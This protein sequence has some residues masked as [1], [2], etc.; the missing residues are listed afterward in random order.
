ME[1]INIGKFGINIPSIKIDVP[2]GELIEKG[3]ITIKKEKK[4]KEKKKET[5]M[6]IPEILKNSMKY[7]E[8]ED[9][10]KINETY[11]IG[12]NL[13]INI[14]YNDELNTLTYNVIEP[15]ISEQLS[16]IY[17]KIKKHLINYLNINKFALR[18]EKEL[19]DYIENKITLAI[20]Q[21]AKNITLPQMEELKYY[22]KRDLV[23]LGRL[24]PLLMD[25]NVEQIDCLGG[26]APIYVLHKKYINLPTNIVFTEEEAN[27]FIYFLLQ[28]SGTFFKDDKPIVF[29][30]L[31]DGSLLE[32]ISPKITENGG[33]FIIKK[34]IKEPNSILELI[35][36]NFL[37]IPMAA[38]IWQM[39][40][41]NKTLVFAGK[42]KSGKH[43]LLNAFSN[44]IKP[45]QKTLV[46][47][48]SNIYLK[49]VQKIHLKKTKY[50]NT[51]DLVEQ[52]LKQ[53]PDYFIL[54]R[55]SGFEARDFFEYSVSGFGAL[56]TFFSYDIEL[57]IKKLKA[58]G[59]KDY[60]LDDSVFIF[61]DFT[62]K[63]NFEYRIVKEIYEISYEGELRKNLVGE[64]VDE[65]FLFYPR[66][67]KFL[68][69]HNYKEM[70]KKMKLLEWLHANKINS[71]S[72]VY[73][74]LQ[75]EEM[76]K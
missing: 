7:P 17:E 64:F 11:Q 55:V 3:K 20:K 35:D 62:R 37:S 65:N 23:G 19:N 75:R 66:R 61:M 33:N 18:N 5:T 74:I 45:N 26:G 63:G 44:L 28:L 71:F 51:M 6:E 70:D 49:N 41:E 1:I 47:D 58:L 22:L 53:L 67:S 21:F 12:D 9:Y 40:Q 34:N 15:P 27:N 25:K 14:R 16:G 56:T 13:F 73:P 39:L 10:K 59:V 72:E 32:A 52:G 30:N 50:I 57:T 54:D 46:I 68:T 24:Y 4:E 69:Q 31:P 76:P 2:E 60:M 43:L 48:N 38:Y 36:K 8:I 29:T 42:A